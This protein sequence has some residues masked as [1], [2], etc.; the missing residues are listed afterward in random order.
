MAQSQAMLYAGLGL[1]SAGSAFATPTLTALVCI[2]APDDRQG[3]ILGTFRSLGSL[4]RAVAPIVAALA[5]WR[6]GSEWPYFGAALL[7]IVP[8]GIA[9]TLPHTS[10]AS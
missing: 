7:L 2:Y 10:D 5:Y 4:G 8:I 9:F 6:Y 1:L 3:E